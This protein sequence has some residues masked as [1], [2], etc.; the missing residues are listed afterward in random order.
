MKPNKAKQILLGGLAAFVLFTGVFATT[1]QAQVRRHPRPHRPVVIYRPYYYDPFYDP[2]WG[3]TWG[4][5]YQTVDPIAYQREQGYSK[6]RSKGKEDAKKGLAANP[7]GQKD[8]LKSNSLAYR[9]AFVLGYNERYREKIRE[10][11]EEGD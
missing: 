11:R 3:P 9:E 4:T 10:L 8:Y 7:T 6:G 2:F 5:S 1:A